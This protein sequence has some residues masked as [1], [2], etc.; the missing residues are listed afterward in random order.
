M[1]MNETFYYKDLRCLYPETIFTV[2]I[3]YFIYMSQWQY[4]IIQKPLKYPPMSIFL[5]R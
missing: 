1:Y 2:I 5:A 4:I 3:L